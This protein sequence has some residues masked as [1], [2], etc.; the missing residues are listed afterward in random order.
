MP[1][2]ETIVLG[3]VATA[4]CDAWQWLAGLAGA[5]FVNP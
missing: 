3:V 2:Y 1:W 5:R 4:L